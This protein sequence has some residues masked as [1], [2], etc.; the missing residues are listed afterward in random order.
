MANGQ[1]RAAPAPLDR[2]GSAHLALAVALVLFPLVASDFFLTQIGAYSMIFGM[3]ALSLMVLAGYG[4][5]VSLAQVTIAGVAG[6][7]VAIF[8]DNNSGVMG[9]GWPWWLTAPVAVALAALASALIGWISVRTEGIY[10]IMITLAV[11][12]ASFY[13]AQQNYTIFNGF[14]GYAGIRAPVV[15]GVNW[16]DPMPF[17]YLCLAVAALAYAAVLYGA[18]STFGL[19]LQ[20]TRD[21][22]RRM[23]ALGY[24]TTAHK[25]FAWFLAGIVAGLAGV[26]LVWFQG[27]ISPGTISVGPAINVLIIAVI[28][29]LKHP[30]GPFL[31]A[32]VVVMMQT[33]AIDIVGAERSNTL[34]GLVFLTIV[35]V[36]PDG[37]L[38]LWER[39]RP[40]LAQPSLE[41]GR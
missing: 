18:R 15:F 25:V 26:L 4:G 11:A 5:M 22:Q 32:V 10:T 20:A 12:T 6:Y 8:G 41:V 1:P 17:Y 19:T 23:R 29:G 40:H 34:I 16:R 3:I 2:A 31:G 33:F 28:G 14:P 21:N 9:L 30:I 24:D 35:F 7:A 27:R 38:G 36:S 13:F 39:A 37:I